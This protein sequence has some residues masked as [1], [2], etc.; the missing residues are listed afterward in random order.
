MHS[1]L[2]SCAPVSELWHSIGQKNP[3]AVTLF[4]GH[5]SACVYTKKE[6]LVFLTNQLEPLPQKQFSENDYCLAL[7]SFPKNSYEQLIDFLVLQANANRNASLH[8]LTR[9]RCWGK[10]LKVTWGCLRTPRVHFWSCEMWIGFHQDSPSPCLLSEKT[11]CIGYL[12]DNGQR[13]WNWHW[14]S[15]GIPSHNI[16]TYE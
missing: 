13:Q 12:G 15:E 14:L 5:T 8:L 4:Q 10:H 3:N 1:V 2:R 6:K 7:E 9:I 16:Y 11:T